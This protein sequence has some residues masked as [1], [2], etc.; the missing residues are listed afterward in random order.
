MAPDE[1][2]VRVAYSPGPRQVD[3]RAL[4]AQAGQSVA[5]VLQASG[6]LTAHALGPMETLVVGV[7]MKTK[8]LDT[9]VRANDRIEVYRPL[10]VDPKEAR[11]Q[12]YRKQGK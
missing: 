1:F 9:P 12:R 11:R 5:D 6:L 3:E 10:L 7:W 2:E 4:R 8:S